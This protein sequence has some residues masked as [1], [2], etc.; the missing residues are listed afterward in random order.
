MACNAF[1]F[2]SVV[3]LA[4]RTAEAVPKFRPL[5]DDG[6]PVV[7]TNVGSIRGLRAEDGNYS[8][9]MG[10][11]FAE[12]DRDNPFGNA[13]PYPNFE[14]TFDAFDDSAIC[15]QTEEFNHTIVGT[16][17]CL[18]VNV[19]VP[20]S[21]SPQNKLPVFVW[22]FGGGFSFGF[23]GRFLYGPSYLVRHDIIFVTLNY[24]VGPYGFMCLDTPEVPGNQGL[25]DQVLAL[26]WVRDNIAAFGGDETKITIGGN[27]A[28]GMA[29][30]FH[31]HY[32]KDE[33]LFHKII[34]QSGT[35]II[36]GSVETGD[37]T[38]PLKLA[39][40]FDHT[41]SDLNDALSFLA[42]VDPH[43]LI[44]ATAETEVSFFVC[45]EKEFNNVESFITTHPVNTKIPRV[46]DIEVMIGFNNDEMYSSFASLPDIIF[47][48]DDFVGTSLNNSFDFEGEED[49]YNEMKEIVTH[50][51]LGDDDINVQLKQ[52]IIDISSD[53]FFNH[54]ILRTVKK[55]LDNGVEKMYLYLF[56][57]S[58][59]RNFV[60]HRLNIEGGG[61]AHADELGYLFDIQYME[62]P[63]DPAD[64]LI[65]DRMTEMWANFV[66]YGDPTPAP[67]ELVPV[68]WPPVT[69]DKWHYLEL[70]TEIRVSTR[71]FQKR[72]AFLD[73]FYKKNERFQRGYE[74]PSSARSIVFDF[75]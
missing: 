10:I 39:E 57:Y 5:E 50:F 73:L 35:T 51:Y 44:A 68:H 27:S 33:N 16:I 18:H 23:A 58:G 6:Y 49:L 22:I 15:P 32:G 31:L 25:K 41:T 1:L 63:L 74:A 12:V 19:Y 52:E 69:R 48:M 36:Y 75:L 30:D 17:D 64:Q 56:S 43:Q 55:Y 59:G 38:A 8:M 7:N 71:P 65:V 66:K 26:R 4:F 40:Y 34:P 67:T 72:M 28:G 24:R 54:P 14:E 9:F 2:V 3:V 60:K 11:P 42:T 45:V 61:A 47:G 53:F 13:I 46:K 20:D 62:K 21:A 70:D 37:S 29:V